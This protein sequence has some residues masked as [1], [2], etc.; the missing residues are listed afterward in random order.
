MRSTLQTRGSGNPMNP[1]LSSNKSLKTK[2][3]DLFAPFF[4][5]RRYRGGHQ[6]SDCRVSPVF[7]PSLAWL[8]TPP[9]HCLG[10]CAVPH[11]AVF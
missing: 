6:R 4:Q 5:T 10:R 8:A 2:N 3:N 7:L 9:L 1:H 11:I